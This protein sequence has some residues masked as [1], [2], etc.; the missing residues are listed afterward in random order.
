MA[1]FRDSERFNNQEDVEDSMKKTLVLFHMTLD[2]S[3]SWLP[4]PSILVHMSPYH[5]PRL[6][7]YFI[8]HWTCLSLD[9]PALTSWST[10]RL[11]T[12]PDSS[13]ISY[14]TGSVCLLTPP[15]LH[16]GPHVA[17]PPSQTLVL[18]HMTLDLSVSWLPRPSILVHMSPYHRP[19]HE[20]YFIWHWI[21]QSLDFP[22]LTSWST[23]HL[24]TVPDSSSISYDTGSVC[25]LTPPPFHLGPHVALPPS[26]TLVLFHMTLDL[27]VSWLPR[28]SILVHMSPYH[29]PKL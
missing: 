14:D 28:P 6:L 24:T 17:L 9:S 29:R 3:V 13:S 18:F 20:F 23:C 26:Q 25:L 2:L 10:C 11:T 4:R 12:V 16:L 15:P 21:C 1:H 8:W 5:R 19:R 22:A 7:F 27:S